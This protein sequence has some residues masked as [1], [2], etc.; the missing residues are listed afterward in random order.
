MFYLRFGTKY[1]KNDSNKFFLVTR[2]LFFGGFPYRQLFFLKDNDIHVAVWG[3]HK[4]MK[5]LGK[6][7]NKNTISTFLRSSRGQRGTWR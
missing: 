4:F 3:L 1:E 5:L 7:R 2:P 6:G